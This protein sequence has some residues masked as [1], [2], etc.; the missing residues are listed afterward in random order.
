MK[1]PPPPKKSDMR[2]LV[3]RNKFVAKK[4]KVGTHKGPYGKGGLVKKPRR[5]GMV[6]TR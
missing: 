3:R 4:R 5:V 6:D 2:C 1:S